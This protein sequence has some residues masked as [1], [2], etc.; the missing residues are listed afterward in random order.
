MRV[1]NII[2]LLSLTFA[3]LGQSIT[4]GDYFYLK[5]SE[6]QVDLILIRGVVL[7]KETL[8]PIPNLPPVITYLESKAENK[9]LVFNYEGIYNSE[10]GTFEFKIP[11][12]EYY[13]ICSQLGYHEIETKRLTLKNNLT[14][15]FLI[16]KYENESFH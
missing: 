13:F 14:L 10:S 3:T 5:D 15:I 1:V 2:F 16:S 8:C 11:K 12:G 7:S 6:P 4:K 9:E